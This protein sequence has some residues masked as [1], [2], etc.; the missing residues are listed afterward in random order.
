MITT[1]NLAR[2]SGLR[3]IHTGV[4]VALAGGLLL[5]AYA[6]TA[7][8]HPA[9][10]ARQ[11]DHLIDSSTVE[12]R[13]APGV[14]P[15]INDATISTPSLPEGASVAELDDVGAHERE[16][17]ASV[18]ELLTISKESSDASA[19]TACSVLWDQWTTYCTLPG[20]P[21]KEIT[22]RVGRAL[23]S[24]GAYR[25]ATFVLEQ[26]QHS[27][28]Y[29]D[30]TLTAPLVMAYHK[31]KKPGMLAD[32][33]V[34]TIEK[35]DPERRA[36]CALAIAEARV[37]LGLY[38]EAESLLSTSSTWVTR[39]EWGQ[40]ARELLAKCRSGAA[41][42]TQAEVDCRRIELYWINE[43]KAAG[44]TTYVRRKALQSVTQFFSPEAREAIVQCVADADPVLKMC[45]IRT[46]AERRDA[47][48]VSIL[49][50]CS[51]DADAGVR[52]EAARALLLIKG[53]K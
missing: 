4:L 14:C 9:V 51:Q 2:R 1:T 48:A 18:S 41:K 8:R 44:N 28:L 35:L 37:E 10:R 12:V 11:G 39:D 17:E 32:W 6:D 15:R 53:R 5:Y 38:R 33:P 29:G 3:S 13:P 23:F 50:A 25:A 16:I 52:R 45:A 20:A 26:Y 43:L 21:R 49:R 24:A 19:S 42:V 47:G 34:R 22:G 7:R 27:F 40:R 36:E 31:D 30:A 46:V